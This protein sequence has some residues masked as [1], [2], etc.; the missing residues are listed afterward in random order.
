MLYSI[1]TKDPLK[2]MG[3]PNK[4]NTPL[5]VVAI[6]STVSTGSEV[7]YNAVFTHEKGKKNLG[8]IAIK[9]FPYYQY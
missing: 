2:Y 9:I 6:P 3:F 5:P 1:K 8:L 4:I 7:I